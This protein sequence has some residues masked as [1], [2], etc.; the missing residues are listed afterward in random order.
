MKATF[1]HKEHIPFL[2]FPLGDVLVEEE[3]KRK[4]ERSLY[5]AM[6]SGN[7]VQHKVKILFIDEAGIKMVETTVWF[8]DKEHI[9]LKGGI[10]LPVKRILNVQL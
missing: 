7:T 4:R 5:Y 6:L 1:I 8:A 9:L 10:S 3:R 2:S